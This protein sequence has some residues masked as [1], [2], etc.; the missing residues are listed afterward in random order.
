MD[1]RVAAIPQ[2]W[3]I[4]E[5]SMEFD[6][7]QMRSLFE[8]GY[9]LIV[10]DRAWANVPPVLDASQQSIPRAGTQFLVPTHG[11]AFRD[12]PRATL[13]ECNGFN[14]DQQIAIMRPL[15]CSRWAVQ[16][17]QSDNATQSGAGE[18]FW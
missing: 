12:E 16:D 7:V 3:P 11:S 5:D 14:V 4:T 2:D 8:R 13:S 18:C 1:F 10:A 15:N 6:P 17:N 9:Q